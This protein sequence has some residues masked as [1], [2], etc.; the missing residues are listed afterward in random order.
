MAPT[1]RKALLAAL[2]MQQIASAHDAFLRDHAASDRAP[3]PELLGKALTMDPRD[4]PG[5]VARLQAASTV[6]WEHSFSLSSNDE[7]GIVL[8]CVV[9]SNALDTG[10]ALSNLADGHQPVFVS[11]QDDSACFIVHGSSGRLATTAQALQP[12]LTLFARVPAAAKLS[13]S[14]FRRGD[15]A[16]GANSDAAPRRTLSDLFFA[17]SARRSRPVDGL[18]VSFAPGAALPDQ[19]WLAEGIAGT[20]HAWLAARLSGTQDADKDVKDGMP[21]ALRESPSL[22][23]ASA[24]DYSSLALSGDIHAT[25]DGIP[26]GP[27]AHVS[28]LAARGAMAER[29]VLGLLAALAGHGA[30]AHVLPIAPFEAH[31]ARGAT[32]VQTSA[33]AASNHL[34]ATPIWDLGLNGTGQIVGI[35]DSGLDTASCFFSESA[36]ATA[37]KRSSTASPVVDT[38]QAKVIMYIAYTDG[39]DT[40]DVSHGTH[41]VGSAVGGVGSGWEDFA[42]TGSKDSCAAA[43]NAC[44]LPDDYTDCS[45][46]VTLPYSKY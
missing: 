38:A 16:G 12:T 25:A 4:R 13:T 31:N 14:L 26:G 36:G 46:Y 30:V 7:P 6:P 23:D 3:R 27:V 43:G 41:V 37:V 45:S 10:E 2:L 24:C 1:R 17:S 9:L 18:V 40:S 32:L 29:C 28:G 19:A 42:A 22:R 34:L 5:I 20:A 39:Q 44:L 33:N 8:A 15:V 35:A 21:L 11:R